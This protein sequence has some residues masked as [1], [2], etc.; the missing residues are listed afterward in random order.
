VDAGRARTSWLIWQLS[1][2]DIS[3]PWD[4]S[5]MPAE[6][7]HRKVQAMPPPGKGSPLDNEELRTVIQWIDMGA[8]YEAV[9]PAEPDARKLAETK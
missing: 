8:Q 6:A 7:R 2:A 5:S 4:R 9:G 1:G 3:R